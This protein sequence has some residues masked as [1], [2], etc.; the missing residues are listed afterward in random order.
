MKS[1]TQ[2]LFLMA[3]LLVGYLFMIHDSTDSDELIADLEA[4]VGSID[5]Q[6]REIEG[7]KND[8]YDEIKRFN[9]NNKT[10][11]D[12]LS[13]S[14]KK[15]NEDLAY[16]QKVRRLSRSEMSTSELMA[17]DSSKISPFKKEIISIEA[18]LEELSPPDVEALKDD[19]KE[20]LRTL[21]NQKKTL[22]QLI[23]DYSTH[24]FPAPST[25]GRVVVEN[26]L[27]AYGRPAKTSGQLH[28]LSDM[29]FGNSTPSLEQIE[30]FRSFHKFWCETYNEDGDKTCSF[31]WILVE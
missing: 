29:L 8:I 11:V 15:L 26:G 14:L 9:V 27:D 31:P 16:N 5:V 21:L 19:I 3:I 4:R 23:I 18:R 2:T 13:Q 1:L 12:S 20:E 28:E 7:L 17:F 6:E 30:T 22:N 25:G 10:E 24:F